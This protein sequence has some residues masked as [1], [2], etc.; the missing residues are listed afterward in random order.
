[1]SAVGAMM[2]ASYAPAAAGGGDPYWANVQLLINGG[3]AN[4]STTI[5]DSSQNNQTWTNSG[6]VYSTAVKK[7]ASSS[8][9]FTSDRLTR[10]LDSQL[11]I[12]ADFTWEAWLYPTSLT[13]AVIGQF[14]YGPLL[15]LINSN[16]SIYWESASGRSTVFVSDTTGTGVLVN[17]TWTHFA[18]T[19]SGNTWK[20][21]SNGTQTGTTKT[22]S[23][24]PSTGGT[25]EI[26]SFNG[27]GN[28]FAGY[29]EGIRITKGV[30]RYTANFTAPTASFPT[31]A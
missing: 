21:F 29:M 19:R 25:Y 2:V 14:L 11:E 28:Y 22:G 18:I 4:N 20:A 15:M 31:S 1:M 8:L 17:N 26:G 3:Q 6:A 30:A 7:F 24:T 5:V 12:P 27:A 23:S 9:A 13:G 16:G 10:S